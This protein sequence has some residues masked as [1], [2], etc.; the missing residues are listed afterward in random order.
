MVE[1][2]TA[3]LYVHYISLNFNEVN[4]SYKSWILMMGDGGRYEPSL[5]MQIRDRKR[6]CFPIS[7]ISLITALISF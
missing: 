2:V 6:A 4:K 1:T 3:V 7:V 5:V